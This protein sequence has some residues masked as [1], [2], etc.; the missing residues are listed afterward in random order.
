MMEEKTEEI[1]V[2]SPGKAIL[3]GEHAV[4]YDKPALAASLDMCTFVRAK[5]SKGND[6]HLKLVDFNK[7]FKWPIKQ[8]TETLYQPSGGGDV[9]NVP[10]LSVEDIECLWSKVKSSFPSDYDNTAVLVFL[11]L[12]SSIVCSNE[13]L[14]LDVEVASCLPIGA[15]LGSSASYT[16]CLSA[17]M[18]TA[19]KAIKEFSNT[20]LD[21]V[22]RWA[23]SAERILHGN[24]SGV[25]NSVSV[26]GGLIKYQSG[27]ITRVKCPTTLE[28]ILINT[29][30][31]R[32]TKKLVEKVRKRNIEWPKVIQP[33]LDG[34]GAII[35][36]VENIFQDVSRINIDKLNELVHINQGL[37]CALGVSHPKLNEICQ[38]AAECGFSAKLTGAGGGGGAFCFVPTSCSKSEDFMSKLEGRGFSC[39]KTK[40]GGP[41]VLLHQNID[42]FRKTRNNIPEHFAQ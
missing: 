28:I 5:I 26:F 32:E 36:S 25:D 15:G 19:V 39:W 17:T 13:P 4:V 14:P 33:V 40:V 1:C 29:K 21:L 34:I 41:G 10:D 37:L 20:D 9:K 2:S 22:N 3:F 16:T 23:F 31:Q 18:L 8:I 7:T 38:L 6:V 27:V 11:Y 42:E 35:E 12:Y 30:V 24:P